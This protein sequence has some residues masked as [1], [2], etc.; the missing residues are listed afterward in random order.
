MKDLTLDLRPSEMGG[1]DVRGLRWPI[2]L[3]DDDN[4][5]VI[6]TYVDHDGQEVVVI[7]RP[8]WIISALVNAGYTAILKNQ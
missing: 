4:L 1:L 3:P 2:E 7:S 5:M 8:S 6:C